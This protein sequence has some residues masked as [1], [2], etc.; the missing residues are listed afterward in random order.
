MTRED[1]AKI[2]KVIKAEWPHRFKDMSAIEMSELL[3]LWADMFNDDDV[4]IVAAAVKCLIVSGNREFAPNVGAIKEQM[5]KL[6][7]KEEMSEA[8]AWNLVYK[9]IQNGYYGAVEEFNKL[10]PILQKVV[11]EPKQLRAWAVMDA[12]EVQSVVAS[13]VQRSYRTVKQ[14]ENEYQKLPINVKAYLTG[15]KQIEGA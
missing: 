12:D 4:N 5:R 10:P 11:G 9:A 3:S 8:E 14:R 6:T 2:L 7:N 1:T 13:N 15:L